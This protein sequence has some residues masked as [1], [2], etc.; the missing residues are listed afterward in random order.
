MRVVA[1]VLEGTFAAA[2]IKQAAGD[3]AQR[4]PVLIAEQFLCL[5]CRVEVRWNDEVACL[6]T[7]WT[8]PKVMLGRALVIRCT[9]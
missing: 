3:L 4:G 2:F 9:P 6:S 7:D 8:R 1:A 5:A